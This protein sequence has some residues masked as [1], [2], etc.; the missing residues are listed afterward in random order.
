MIEK[1]TFAFLICAMTISGTA[2]AGSTSQVVPIGEGKY[3]LTGRN[4][5]VFGSSDGI[6]AK[7]MQKANAFCQDE[8]KSEAVLLDVSGESAAVGVRTASSTIYFR[9]GASPAGKSRETAEASA[10]PDSYYARVEQLQQ[11]IL[12]GDIP[13]VKGFLSPSVSPAFTPMSESDAALLEGRSTWWSG[14]KDHWSMHLKNV[15]GAGV[16]AFEFTLANGTCSAPTSNPVKAVVQLARPIPS[17]QSAVINF[18]GPLAAT[19]DGE[20]MCGVVSAA[21]ESKQ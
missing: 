20:Q 8:A 17:G 3:M 21:W 19:V 4:T 11:G 13:V 7:L 9:C 14:S 15:T 16:E 18:S 12:S 1:H 10:L 5:T 6:A 2:L